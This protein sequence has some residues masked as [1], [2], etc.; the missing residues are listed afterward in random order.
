M[1][2]RPVSSRLS[3]VLAGYSARLSGPDCE[4]R[5][6]T[7]DSRTVAP[8]DLFVVRSG[9][10]FD[11]G[12]FIG[13][14]VARGCVAVLAEDLSAES[15]GLLDQHPAVGI[16]ELPELDQHLGAIAARFYGRPSQSMQVLGVTG[17]NGKTSCVQLLAQAL[18]RG[19]DE[20]AGTIGTLGTGLVGELV[21]ELNTT[22]DVISVHRRL[23]DFVDAGCRHAAMEV[24]SHAVVQKRID[25]VHFAIAALTN[26]SRDHLDYHGT[27]A[28]YGRAKAGLFLE[29]PVGTAI[30]NTDDAFGRDLLGRLPTRMRRVSYGSADADVTASDVTAHAGGLSFHLKTP[31]GQGEVKSGL[32]GQFNVENLLVVAACLG[33]LGFGMARLLKTLGELQPVAGRMQRVSSLEGPLVVVD[34]AHTPDA[35]AQ[36]L[37]SL[38][39][40]T[41][42]ELICVFGC[43]GDR[44]S[45]KRPL[46]AATAEKLADRLILTDDNPRNEDGDGIIQDMLA[47]LER[48]DEI[49]VVRDRRLAI[50][51]GIEL[52]GP[53][54]TV[55]IAGKGHETYQEIR[56]RRFALND[57][58]EAAAA[59]KLR[60]GP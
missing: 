46:M 43:G 54:D 42:S 53:D 20:P 45:G 48:T 30:V 57:V 19:S 51:Q 24:S 22:P 60:S 40:H 23:A 31:W 18:H 34:Y 1:T 16:A 6:M 9:A 8:G 25:G 17:T 37:Q 28:A 47:G 39:R 2:A 36:A 3:Q 7:L 13:D 26:L 12:A 35:L 11:G 58:E 10:R 59:L 56:G 29:H 38:R 41:R 44:D 14:A 49:S 15:A 33:T 50:A 55:L 5:G 52:A 32:V 4:V 21:P 27:M